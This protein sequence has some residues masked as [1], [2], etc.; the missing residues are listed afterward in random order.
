[1]DVGIGRGRE[2]AGGGNVQRAAVLDVEVVVA[3]VSQR[4]RAGDFQPALQVFVGAGVVYRAL[5]VKHG[6]AAAAHRARL[7]QQLV[8]PDRCRAIQRTAGQ[9]QTGD[10]TGRADGQR[11]AVEPE[12]AAAGNVGDLIHRDQ[13]VVH[14]H[15][16][17]TA[18][19]DMSAQTVVGTAVGGQEQGGACGCCDSTSCRRSDRDGTIVAAVGAFVE[20]DV[21]IG[22][23]GER[24]GGGN[25]QRAAVLDVEHVVAAVSQRERAGD[26]Q[27]ALQVFVGDGVVYRALA[28]EHGRTA[29]AHRA[30]LPQQLVQPD[31]CRAIQR[32]AGQFQTGDMTGRADGQRAAVEPEHAAAG[33]V[34]DLIHRDQTAV[35][36]HDARTAQFDMSAQAVV[37]TAVGGQEQGGACGYRDSTS[38][39]RSDRGYAVMAAVE[40]FVEVNVGVGRRGQ[41]AGSGN[42]QRTAVTDVEVV[43]AAVAQRERA[44]DLQSALQVLVGAG[45]VQG[46]AARQQGDATAKHRPP[47]PD[48]VATDLQVGVT[49]QRATGHDEAAVDAGVTAQRKCAAGQKEVAATGDRGLVQGEC[50]SRKLRRGAGRDLHRFAGQIEAARFEQ[51]TT[52][53]QRREAQV[54]QGCTGPIA[55]AMQA[56]QAAAAFQMT[57]DVHVLDV[58]AT[59]AAALGQQAERRDTAAARG[60]TRTAKHRAVFQQQG[61]ALGNHQF[62]IDVACAAQGD[63]GVEHGTAAAA[64][65]SARPVEVVAQRQVAAAA[66]IGA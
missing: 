59:A 27:P 8:Q 24:A 52:T 54:C 57:A 36:L 19:F 12:H 41:R 56:K 1:M 4:E 51:E 35:H 7:P 23:G 22:R 25:M 28:V 50:S 63:R 20:M 46:T 32:T 9:F 17:G 33:N 15:D 34:G 29:A 49:A 62:A 30:R 11:A 45:I 53:V 65:A 60:G 43:V 48:E 58:G 13:T 42:V 21:G 31:R 10:M 5:A 39:H 3:A 66:Q 16:A 55:V 38:R 44:G 61:T 37:G 26:F 47:G 64:H 14:L 6:C 2:R 40:A 18:Q